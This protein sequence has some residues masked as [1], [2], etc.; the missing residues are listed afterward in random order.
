MHYQKKFVSKKH[1]VPQHFLLIYFGSLNIKITNDLKI[2]SKTKRNFKKKNKT[3]FREKKTTK[4]EILRK[5]RNLRKEIE[6]LRK[7]KFL[8]QKQNEILRKTR[9]KKT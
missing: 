1:F 7:N 5:K 8:S 3:K 6:I 2:R 4:K 9:R